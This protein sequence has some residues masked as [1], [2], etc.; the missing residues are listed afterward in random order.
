MIVRQEQLRI[1]LPLERIAEIC[2]EFGVTELSVFG[3]ALRD[4]FRSDS[5]VDFLVVFDSPDLGPWMSRLS[6]LQAELSSL[7]RR[8][9]DVAL[10]SGV[11]QSENYIR[12][13]HIL[14]SAQAVYVA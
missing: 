4:D 11:E 10:R 6:E 9:V 3:S 8:P 14:R 1:E 5:D 12:R 7:L 13:R 2:Q